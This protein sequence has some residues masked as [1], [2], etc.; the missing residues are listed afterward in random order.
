MKKACLLFLG[1]VLLLV[2]PACTPVDTEHAETTKADSAA[3]TTALA[4]DTTAYSGE[5]TETTAPETS[6]DNFPKRIE[7]IDIDQNIR[8]DLPIYPYDWGYM[9]ETAQ[10]LGQMTLEMPLPQDGTYP[11]ERVLR[12]ERTL[13]VSAYDRADLVG[14]IGEADNIVTFF[15][16][17]YWGAAGIYTLENHR[18]LQ[19]GGD[20]AIYEFYHGM[21][22]QMIEI[23]SVEDNDFFLKLREYIYLIMDGDT[24]LLIRFFPEAL[25]SDFVIDKTA[26]NAI[27]DNLIENLKI[28]YKSS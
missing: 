21:S 16:K 20:L 26:E 8:L 6:G 15:N 27:F 18:V 10:P 9:S 19:S 25:E 24:V 23:Y 13:E 17:L 7:S 14:K 28:S 2:L 11:I 5:G 22:A 1:L 3:E 4:D 12:G